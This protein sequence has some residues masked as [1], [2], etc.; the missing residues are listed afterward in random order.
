MANSIRLKRIAEQIRE[1][2]AALLVREV[3]D[4]RLAGI[5]ITDVKVDRELAFADIFVSAVEGQERSQ[6]VIAGLRHA[7]GFLRTALAAS[8]DLRAMPR[9]RFHWDTTPEKADH[10]EKLLL[11]LRWEREQREGLAALPGAETAGEESSPEDD[12]DE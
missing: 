11:E 4:P 7:S 9:L 2:L 5:T 12:A 3:A 8:L 6:E 10:I 1:D